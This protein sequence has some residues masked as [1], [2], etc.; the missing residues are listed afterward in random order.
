VRDQYQTIHGAPIAIDKSGGP[1]AVRLR[2]V[3]TYQD[4]LASSR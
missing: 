2:A 1:L 4:A 3:M